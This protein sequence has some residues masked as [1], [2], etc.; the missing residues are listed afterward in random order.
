MT[1][2]GWP[3]NRRRTS[4]F[5]W[6]HRPN[7]HTQALLNVRY[8]LLWWWHWE[9]DSIVPF[10]GWILR[11]FR[12]FSLSRAAAESSSSFVCLPVRYFLFFRR[13]L[14][15]QSLRNKNSSYTS[16]PRMGFVWWISIHS[17]ESNPSTRYSLPIGSCLLLLSS[18]SLYYIVHTPIDQLS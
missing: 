8:C 16:L 4:W 5:N 7:T 2:D 13:A 15:A 9:R 12:P 6:F 17:G 18:Y 11:D 14:G 1:R 3:H 10:E